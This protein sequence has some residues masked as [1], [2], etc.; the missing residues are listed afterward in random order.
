MLVLFT[1]CEVLLCIYHANWILKSSSFPK[2]LATTLQT[3][4]SNFFPPF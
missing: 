2:Y 1:V 4:V 3:N